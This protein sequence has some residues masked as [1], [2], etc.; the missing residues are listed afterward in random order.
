MVMLKHVH[1]TSCSF[2]RLHQGIVILKKRWAW[3]SGD[4]GASP[5]WNWNGNERP[6]L[7]SNWIIPDRPLQSLVDLPHWRFLSSPPL[8]LL[9]LLF[10]PSPTRWRIAVMNIPLKSLFKWN[11]SPKRT[12]VFIHERSEW[13]WDRG[14]SHCLSLAGLCAFPSRPQWS[15]IYCWWKQIVHRVLQYKPRLASSKYSKTNPLLCNIFRMVI[16]L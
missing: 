5:C 4:W 7:Q 13:W 16:V 11:P 6:R 2:Q 1:Q 12:P 3:W 9:L 10:L 14:H 15:T 8:L